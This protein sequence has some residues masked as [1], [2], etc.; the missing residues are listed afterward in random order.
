[1]ANRSHELKQPAVRR[2]R[3]WPAVAAVLLGSTAVTCMSVAGVLA[4]DA[5]VAA[6]GEF[7]PVFRTLQQEWR[8]GPKGRTL[9]ASTLEPL[10]RLSR[11]ADAA[12]RGRILSWWLSQV[13]TRSRD[14]APMVARLHLEGADLRGVN[15]TRPGLA[16]RLNAASFSAAYA[17]GEYLSGRGVFTASLVGARLSQAKLDRADLHGANLQ[18]ADLR[19]ASLR[20]AN[21]AHAVLNGADLRGADLRGARLEGARLKG[22]RLKG[23]RLDGIQLAEGDSVP[24][25]SAAP[26]RVA[27]FENRIRPLLVTRCI[28]CHGPKK[29]EG[30]L[31]LDTESGLKQGGDGGPVLLADKPGQSP[32]LLAVR[33]TGELKM[34]PTRPLDDLSIAHLARWIR[35]GAAWPDGVSLVADTVSLRGGPITDKERSFW[36]FQPVSDPR[37]PVFPVGT[38]GIRNDVDRFVLAQLHAAGLEPVPEA[39]RRTLIRRVT[40]D[41]TGLPPT[42]EDVRKYLTDSKPG[43]LARVV[44]RLLESREY[45][46]RWGRHWL[47]VVRYADTA[48]ETADFPTPLAYK[49][50]NWV[51]DAFNGDLPYDVFVRHQVAG[52]L[53]AEAEG[54]LDDDAYRKL[55]IAT[56]FIAVSRRFGFDSENYHNLTIQDTIDTLGQAVLGLSLGCARCHDHKYDPVNVEDYYAWYGIFESTRYSFP[57]SE[58]KKKPYDLFPVVRSERAEAARA[59]H[60][61][62]LKA[63]DGELGPLAVKVALLESAASDRPDSS[64]SPQRRPGSQ[65][66]KT[67]RLTVSPWRAYLAG[68]LLNQKDANRDGHQGFHVWHRNSLPLI[69]VNTSN[70]LLRVPGDVRPGAV[71]VHP[72]ARD[73]I[74]IA[75]RSPFTGRVRI[76]G[77]VTDRHVSCGDS[78]RWHVDRLDAE[79]LHELATAPNTQGRSRAIADP[80]LMSVPVR[81]GDYL[82]LVLSPQT[83]FGCDLTE[84]EWDIVELLDASDPADRRPERWSLTRDVVRSFH[85]SNPH[86]GRNDAGETWSFFQADVDRGAA[87]ARSA[88]LVPITLTWQPG[89]EDLAALQ[90]RLRKLKDRKAALAMTEP[91]GMH[92]GAIDVDMPGDAMIQIRG[93]RAHSG[94]TVLRR[95]L[96][97]LGGQKLEDPA[98]SGRRELARWLTAPNNPLTARVMAN[99]VWAWHFGNGL[100]ATANDFGQRGDRPSHPKLL[101]WLACRFREG[102][103]SVKALHRLMMNSATYRRSSRLDPRAVTVDPDA[104][105]LWRFNRRRLSAEEIRDAMMFV[106]G[107][108]D[109]SPGGAHPFPAESSWTFS[110]HGPFYGLYPSKRRSVYLMQQRLKRHPFLALFDGADPNVSTSRRELTTV[111][112]Q[113]LY[114]MNSGFVHE[115]SGRLARRVLAELPADADENAVLQR[116]WKLVLSR[117]GTMD[118]LREGRQFL[119]AYA[120]ALDEGQNE[121]RGQL[122]L[123]ALFRTLMTRNEFLFVD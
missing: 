112:T 1:M 102:R 83:S 5:D 100:V 70:T 67:R 31:R 120:A 26:D 59:S 37:P 123:A 35:E 4:E 44:D 104:R 47:D 88:D 55:R 81:T 27:F 80:K 61:A 78:V 69:G 10:V 77:R 56:G 39:D 121:Q 115:Q 3:S 96:E 108:L 38:P 12:G 24:P 98:A 117:P 122:A 43:A 106:S 84:I 17:S 32:L 105:M 19:G 118:E 99:R 79:G 53:I 2:V 48:G 6:P 7:D 54:D 51:I 9:K 71:V 91:V 25:G 18:E 75:W 90:R 11:R 107:D 46:V 94:D 33:R 15:L 87:W 63:I 113:S 95:N 20:Q 34:P 116:G 93:D 73:G 16:D 111:P 8:P 22:A 89:E 13:R 28:K 41:L 103:F 50:R 57:G 29:A 52:D 119:A 97:I 45:G 66:G 68:R 23:A 36:S 101:D 58:Q 62:R 30:G 74:G 72:A 109:Q 114:L 82:Q 40:Y 60:A 42:P 65:A 49:Y 85:R 92:Y 110:Q 21:L 86:P 64:P 14:L 76:S